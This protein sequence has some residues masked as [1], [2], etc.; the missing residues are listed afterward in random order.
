M[1][2]AALFDADTS[3]RVFWCFECS[4]GLD[5]HERKLF[6]QRTARGYL[7]SPRPPKIHK[8]GRPKRFYLTGFTPEQKLARQ[9]AQ[10]KVWLKA[11]PE[12]DKEQ[13]NV[14]K[15]KRRA[16]ERQG[17][18]TAAQ[19]RE[20]RRK[21]GKRCAMCRVAGKM[22]IDHIVPLARGGLHTRSNIQFL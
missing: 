14:D 18:L 9:R 11:H 10:T 2:L 22:T 5:R 8:P 12:R 3:R 19:V 6:R 16:F 20:H 21:Y 13:R 1:K 15:G 7:A 4:P 17:D